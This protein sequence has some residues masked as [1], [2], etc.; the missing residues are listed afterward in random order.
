MVF[1]NVRSIEQPTE[2][3]R[4]GAEVLLLTKYEAFVGIKKLGVIANP[5]SVLPS[6]MEHIVDKM[7]ED[8]IQGLLPVELTA[9]FGPEHG[10]RGDHQAGSGGAKQTKDRQTNLTVYSTYG[11]KQ[12]DLVGL[13]KK[14][15]VDGIVFDIQDVGARYY[16]FIW[17]MFDMMCAAAATKNNFNFFVLD[18]PNPLGGETVRGPMLQ[19]EYISGVG[20]VAGIPAVH[21]MTVGELAKYFNEKAMATCDVAS[22][23]IVQ[24][25]NLTVVQMEGW[26]TSKPFPTNQLPWV[27][28][29]PN[30]PTLETAMVYPGTCLLEGTSLSE[31]RGTTRPFQIIG[32]AYLDYT[33]SL[34]LMDA[35]HSMCGVLVRETFFIPTFSKFAGNISAGVDITVTDPSCFDPMRLAVEILT[36]AKKHAPGNFSW[37]NGN[38]VDILS[39]SNFTRIAIDEARSVDSI[40]SHYSLELQK[41]GF[42]EE[43]KSVLLYPR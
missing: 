8:S 37:I 21:G 7:H 26:D 5:T 17:T 13:I 18:R 39:G 9:V 3:I 6:S 41:S 16:T 15:G 36:L 28:P 29:S 33:F 22:S 2:K 23:D 40:M 11:M 42:M 38:D 24:V 12:T 32:A 31:G 27:L 10:F 30:M 19:S 4:V 35:V 43:R 20:K 1:G 25:V 14:T 34:E